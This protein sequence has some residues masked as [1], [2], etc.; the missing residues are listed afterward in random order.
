MRDVRGGQFVPERDFRDLIRVV[1][2]W[3]HKNGLFWPMPARFWG[4]LGPMTE[5]FGIIA[6]LQEMMLQSWEGIIRLFP[7]WPS[8]I[9]AEFVN[10]RAEGAFLVSCSYNGLRVDD[11]FIKSLAGEHCRVENPWE[12]S[13]VRVI[14]EDT[15][16]SVL[17]ENS[18]VLSFDTEK[19]KKY[20][21]ECVCE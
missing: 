21:L 15:G 19:G 3:R 13:Y 8:E 11:V 6:P 14:L 1:N 18:R 4:R 20:R 5:M 16:E 12:G 9:K 2:R 7:V 17:K 10:F